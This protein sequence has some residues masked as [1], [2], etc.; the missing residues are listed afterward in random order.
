MFPCLFCHAFK[1]GFRWTSS[2]TNRSVTRRPDA[3]AWKRF[4]RSEFSLIHI[5]ELKASRTMCRS[6]FLVL[7]AQ[8]LWHTIQYLALYTFAGI[9]HCEILSAVP[10]WEVTASPSRKVEIFIQNTVRVECWQKVE[11]R[12]FGNTVPNRGKTELILWIGN[13]PERLFDVLL[14][15]SIIINIATTGQVDFHAWILRLSDT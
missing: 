2:T 15:L 5:F 8:H 3:D 7:S 9:T 13:S 10:R 6:L 1:L 4:Q 12:A 14:A 11:L